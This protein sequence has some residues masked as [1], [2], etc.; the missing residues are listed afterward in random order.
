MTIVSILI[1]ILFGISV[2]LGLMLLYLLWERLLTRRRARV[3]PRTLRRR[4][5]Y[6]SNGHRSDVTI[7]RVQR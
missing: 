6:R 1:D 7:E 3:H 4:V 5:V 2:F